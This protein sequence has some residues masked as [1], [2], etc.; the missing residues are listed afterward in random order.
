[1]TGRFRTIIQ[2]RHD[3]IHNCDRPKVAP[4]ALD[5]AGTVRNVIRD[6][7]FLVTRCDAHVEQE[8]GEWMRIDCGFSN[9]TV[10][11]VGY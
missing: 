10:A 5:R 9:A 3:C 7:R 4:Q 11:S 6:V 2:R 8:F 1:M